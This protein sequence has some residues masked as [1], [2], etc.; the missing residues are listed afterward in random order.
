MVKIKMLLDSKSE[1]GSLL[2]SGVV[3]SVSEI[4]AKKLVSLDRAFYYT[5]IKRVVSQLKKYDVDGKFLTR[6]EF[7]K[8]KGI[9]MY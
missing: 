8:R 9:R 7:L 4:F 5:P 6:S 2:Y 3:Y 1:D